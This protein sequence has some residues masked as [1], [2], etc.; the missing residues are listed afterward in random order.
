LRC[1][2]DG[3]H[4]CDVQSGLSTAQRPLQGGAIDNWGGTVE[5]TNSTIVLNRADADGNGSGSGGGIYNLNASSVAHL[6][7]TILAGN[8]LGI[9][10]SDSPNDLAGVDADPASSH[11]LIGDAATSGGLIDNV[12]GNIVGNNG[13]SIDIATVIIPVLANNGGPTLTHAF[14]ADSLAVDAGDNSLALDA[15]GIP[16]DYDQR[17]AGFARVNNGTVNI[18][19][20]EVSAPPRVVTIDIKPGSDSNS[21]NLASNG[22][23]TVAIFTTSDFDASQ[24]DVSTV[25]FAGANAVHGGL[26]DVDGDGDLDMIVHFRVQDT[27]L[28]NIYAEL[29]S[30]DVNE[31]GLLDSNRQAATVTLGGLTTTDEY[32]TGFDEMELF[33]S[34][35][36]LREFQEDLAA[37]GTF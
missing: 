3:I 19:A 9:A 12:N 1:K 2:E 4:Q 17:G 37:A 13:G 5:S 25:V 11:N 27:I 18:G 14:V 8:L 24:V 28:A 6:N 21:N 16:L 20:V 32:F 26:E 29:L 36:N 34:G 31:D 30:D 33:L 35:K 22:V 10:G 7:N 23:I 15:N